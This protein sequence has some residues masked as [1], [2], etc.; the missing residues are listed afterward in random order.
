MADN[1]TTRTF[2]LGGA[3]YT[4]IAEPLNRHR[5]QQRRII[6]TLRAAGVEPS[7]ANELASLMVY[8]VDVQNGWRPPSPH[9][10]S[11]ELLRAYEQWLDLPAALTDRWVVEIFT[12]ATHPVTS[13]VKPPEGASD[14]N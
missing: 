13:P 3:T 7:T 1:T 8:T 12:S 11:D 14:P 4:I 2:E 10:S 6:Q 5:E 9:A